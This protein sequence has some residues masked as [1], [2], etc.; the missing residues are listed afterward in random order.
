MA[1]SMFPDDF[2][3]NTIDA[4]TSTEP[5]MLYDYLID[6]DNGNIVLD[7]TTKSAIIVSGLDAIIVQTYRKL[8]TDKGIYL[9]YDNNYGNKL[10]TLIGK[11]K[12]Y[13]DTYIEEFLISCLVDNTYVKKITDIETSMKSNVYSVYF[14]MDTIY[15][16]IPYTYSELGIEL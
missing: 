10:K 13:A 2:Y 3:N 16:K 6:L 7:E 15:G 14:V 5:D 8:H 9:I 12:K 4:N 1:E 11:G